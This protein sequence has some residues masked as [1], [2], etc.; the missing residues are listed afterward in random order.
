MSINSYLYQTF[1]LWRIWWRKLEHIK[2]GFTEWPNPNPSWFRYNLSNPSNWNNCTVNPLLRLWVPLRVLVTRLQARLLS[3]FRL[4]LVYFINVV[5]FQ[6]T[7]Q[8]CLSQHLP[9]QVF[10]CSFPWSL[11]HMPISPMSTSPGWSPSFPTH[12][13]AASSPLSLFSG[14]LLVTLQHALLYVTWVLSTKADSSASTPC[15]WLPALETDWL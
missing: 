8:K 10:S 7:F 12:L 1:S 9:P 3:P 13:P 4:L 14:Q 2:V 5:S 6:C 11:L 15:S